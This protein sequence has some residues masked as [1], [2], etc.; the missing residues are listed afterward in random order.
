MKLDFRNNLTTSQKRTTQMVTNA[1]FLLLSKKNFD[2]I[3]VREIC[4]LSLIPHSTFYNYFEDKYDVF[5]WAFFHIIYGYYP[6]M[7]VKMNHYDNIEDYSERV[8]NFIDDYKSIISKIV[9]HNPMNGTFH[10]LVRQCMY[11]IGEIVADNCTRDKN[12]DFPYEVLFNNY[13]NGFLEIFNQTFYYKKEYT[14]KQIKTYMCD[15]FDLRQVN[16]LV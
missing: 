10:Q 14:R 11:E 6:E 8:C 15:L 1:F 4:R 16:N 3:T 9:I 13:I 7:D 5:R 12:F 2:D